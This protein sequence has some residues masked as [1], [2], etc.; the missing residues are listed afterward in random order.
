MQN[1]CVIIPFFNEINTI[2]KSVNRVLKLDIF[3]QIILADDSSF[4]GSEIIAYNFSNKYEKVVYLKNNKNIGKG[5]A[6]NLAKKHIKTSHV[7]IHDADLEYF[8]IDIVEMVKF[9]KSN[10]NALILGS[11]FIGSKKRKN[12][13]FRTFLA[14]HVMSLFFSIINGYRVSDVASCYKLMPS[15]FFKNVSLKEKGFS[16]EI[17]ILSK[18]LKYNKKIVEVPINYHGRSYEEGKKI[19]AIDGLKYL[20]YTIKYRFLR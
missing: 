4:D 12:I 8:P 9:S 16:I 17:E 11:R 3:D 10:P 14:N 1:L 19:K 20:L 15:K 5:A 18:F 7:V 6:L 13:Y 2:S